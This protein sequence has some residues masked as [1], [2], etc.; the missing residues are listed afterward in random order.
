[1][2]KINF[3]ENINYTNPLEQFQISKFTT[4][5][6]INILIYLSIIH[7]LYFMFSNA[8]KYIDIV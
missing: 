5:N 1:M 7:I 4:I 2:S 8:N 3:L 6:I